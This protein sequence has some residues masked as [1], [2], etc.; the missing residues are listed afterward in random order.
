MKNC[1]KCKV[2]CRFKV[3]GCAEM[4]RVICSCLPCFQ[5]QCV[6]CDLQMTVAQP[7]TGPGAQLFQQSGILDPL[8]MALCIVYCPDFGYQRMSNAEGHF[9][10]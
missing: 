9:E 2:P 8:Y 1:G 6:S 7:V 10:N 4:V 5:F 3:V